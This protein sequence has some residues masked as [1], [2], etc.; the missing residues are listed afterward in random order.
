MK[1][2]NS[3]KN[4]LLADN[5]VIAKT[6]AKRMVGLLSRREFKPGEAMVITSC[7]AVQTFFMRFTIDVL[8]MDKHNK[9]IKAIPHLRPY[10]ITGIYFN[11]CTAIELPAGTIDASFTR[12][13][14]TL[15][16]K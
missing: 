7:N 5:I 13:G 12:E 2:I 11:A 3:A 10:R 14:D 1:I 4:T 6:P 8:F 15:L 16:L 9:V